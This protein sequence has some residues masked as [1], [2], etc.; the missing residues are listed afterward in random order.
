MEER[1]LIEGCIRGESKARKMMYELHAPSMMSV[2]SR[3]V[4]NRETARDLLH[5]GFVKLFT[6][7]HTYS[8]AGSFNGWVRRIFVT[9]ALEYLRRNKR[10]KFGVDDEQMDIQEEVPD[11]SLF[12][13]LSTEDL[14]G[15]IARLSDKYRIVFNMHAI[16]QYTHKEIA[17]KLEINENTVRSQYIRA[18]QMLQGMLRKEKGEM[19]KRIVNRY[20]RQP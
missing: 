17:Q 12:D 20:D 16:E 1:Q 8:G 3:Y 4:C 6:K 9:T 10:L 11:I 5:D 18:Q 7:I 13:H 19:M 15:L 14:L 2:C